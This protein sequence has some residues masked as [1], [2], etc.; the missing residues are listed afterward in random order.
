MIR[1]EILDSG[2]IRTYSDTGMQII[3]DG[4]GIL[5]EEAVDPVEI[6]RT[7]TESDIPIEDES[8]TAEELLDIILGGVE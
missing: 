8:G 7:Y 3:Q 2:L 1:T 6:N 5:Y 4:T